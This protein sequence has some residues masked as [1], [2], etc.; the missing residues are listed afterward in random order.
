MSQPDTTVIM[1]PTDRLVRIVLPG[2]IGMVDIQVGLT[3]SDGAPVARVDVTSDTDRYGPALDGRN[4]T[5][6]NGDP[7][8][9]VVF[10][11]GG[12]TP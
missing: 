6:T 12:P 5:V 1:R 4:Y 3:R 7:G 11:T 10:L 8:P 2:G 9:G